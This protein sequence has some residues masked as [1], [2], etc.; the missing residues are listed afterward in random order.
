METLSGSM[1]ESER[2]LIFVTVAWCSKGL[3]GIV[4]QC[5][6]STVNTPGPSINA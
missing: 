1:P 5:V 2:A 3:I 6:K 4:S